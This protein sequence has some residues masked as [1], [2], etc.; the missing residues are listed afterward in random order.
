VKLTG[1]GASDANVKYAGQSGTRSSNTV[2]FENAASKGTIA[3]TGSGLVSQNV[4][5]NFG[6]RSTIVIEIEVVKASTNIVPQTVAEAGTDVKN[7]E[8]NQDNT[9]VT[10]TLNLGTN[11][12]NA[13]YS[14]AGTKRDYSL[15]V[16]TKAV[17]PIAS[18]AVNQ[19]YERSPY[20][21][22]CEP[23]G[24]VFNPAAHIELN[25]PGLGEIGDAAI[26]LKN[27]NENALNK[28]VEG[29]V[30]KAD[31]P[32]FSAWN[33]LVTAVCTSINEETETIAEGSLVSGAN[34]VTYM[35]RTGFR[36]DQTGILTTFLKLLFGSSYTQVP[37]TTVINAS[38]TGTYSISQSKVIMTFRAG[39]KTFQ[40]EVY[41]EPICTVTYTGTVT[42]DT[43]PDVPTHVGGSND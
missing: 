31:V 18:A 19:T 40:A 24:V 39:L 3:V 42:P 11:S 32:H 30:L 27:G 38:E 23:S 41:G 15:V 20:S 37:K 36:T 35:Q 33:L 4:P 43:K 9:G 16:Y 22:D 14:G 26:D 21:V 29:N 12:S 34:K 1:N 28:K 8:G 13:D 7:D 2:T 10:T 25:V 6:E 17:A 5:I